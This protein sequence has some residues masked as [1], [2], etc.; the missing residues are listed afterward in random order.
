[1]KLSKWFSRSEFECKCQCGWDTV[2]VELIT[3][4]NDVREHFNAAVTI[5]SG[6]RCPAHNKKIGGS[7]GSMHIKARAA[8]FKVKGVH[9]DDVADYLEEKYPDQYGIGRYEGRTHIDTKSGEKR[10]WDER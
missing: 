6:T 10:R 8:D 7:R 5:N 1:M 4:L 3:V 9:A 2:D